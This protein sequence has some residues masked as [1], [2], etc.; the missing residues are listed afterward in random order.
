VNLLSRLKKSFGGLTRWFVQASLIKKLI[1]L[2]IIVLVGWFVFSRIFA[3]NGQRPQYQTAQ[4]TR[5]SL[6]ST[7]TESGNVSSTSQAGVGSPT[8]G[9]LT[10]MYVKD[11]DMVNVGQDLFKVKSTATA[12]EVASAYSTYQNALVSANTAQQNKMAAQSTLEKDRQAILDTQDAVTFLNGNLG[13][14]KPNPKTGTNYTQNEIDSINSQLTSAQE[15]FAADEKKYT[16]FD[17][18]ITAAQA[19]LTAAKLAY[20]AT[21]DSVVTAPIDGTVANIAVQ[22][23]DQVSASSGNLSSELNSNNSNSSNTNSPVLSIGNFSKPYIKVQASEVDVPTIKTGQKAT[24]TLD[25]YPDKTFVGNVS[26]VDTVGAISSGVVSYNIYISFVAPP[27]NILPGMSATATIQ[28]AQKD[29][30]LMVSTSAVQ[31]TNG[32]TTVRVLQ[33]GQ[34]TSVP[35]TTGISSDTDTEITSGLSEGQTVVTGT[36]STG[37]TQSNGASPFGTG[38][39]IGGFGGGF[40]GGAVRV[41]G[42]GGGARGGGGGR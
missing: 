22:V 29:N 12:Q 25:A 10:E 40:G 19:A 14:S 36:I 3:A 1:V 15:T 4:V 8:T 28:T 5:G 7:L 31:T 18:N 41:G 42:G 21:Q 16:Q 13:G 26:Q 35:V 37:A 9:V 27:D 38:G 39:R 11:G 32:Q 2:V 34:V 20:D 6:I 24:I 17:Q 30:V 33:N 23:G